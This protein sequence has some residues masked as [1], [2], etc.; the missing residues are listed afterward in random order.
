MQT[1]SRRRRSGRLTRRSP[2]MGARGAPEDRCRLDPVGELEHTGAETTRRRRGRSSDRTGTG[3]RRA[4]EVADRSPA[5]SNVAGKANGLSI[6]DGRLRETSLSS[7]SPSGAQRPGPSTASKHDLDIAVNC[8][9]LRHTT[10]HRHLRHGSPSDSVS[11]AR[12]PPVAQRRANNFC[13]ACQRYSTGS[14]N[15]TRPA[16]GGRR[17]H[18]PPWRSIVRVIVTRSDRRT[19]RGS[20][21]PCGPPPSADSSRSAQRRIDALRAREIRGVKLG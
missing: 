1:A 21:R 9:L 14:R 8:I 10:L 5:W 16:A 7:E 6:I 2:G 15:R 3:A 20:A 4:I 17:R 12:R 11:L 18:G 19:G 13:R